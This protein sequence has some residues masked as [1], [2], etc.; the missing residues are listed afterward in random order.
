M[1][2]SFGGSTVGLNPTASLI[3]VQGTLYGTT[4]FGGSYGYGTVFSFDLNTGTYTAA[5]SFCGQQNCT[6]GRFQVTL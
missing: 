6:D 4:T 2:V 3:D 5:Y 1:L